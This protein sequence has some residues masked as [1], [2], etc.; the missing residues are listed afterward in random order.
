MWGRLLLE[1]A[2]THGDT[3]REGEQNCSATRECEGR[4]H[5]AGVI[6]D[7]AAEAGLSATSGRTGVAA[8]A[9]TGMT[10][11]VVVVTAV[12]TGEARRGKRQHEHHD[13]REGDDQPPKGLD[14][15]VRNLR[16]S[17]TGSQS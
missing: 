14:L 6:C 4:R 3:T 13:P 9:A 1:P 17:I 15:H 5:V 7:D 10:A 12:F 2:A 16:G 8:T 11:A